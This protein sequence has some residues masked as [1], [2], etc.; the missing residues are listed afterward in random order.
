MRVLFDF[1]PNHTG[2]GFWAFQDVVE[3]GP[4]S[5][6]WDWYFI[7]EW[8]FAPGDGSA[9]EG[10]WGLGSLPKLNTENPEVKGYLFDVALHWLDFG[11]DGFRVDVPNELPNAHEFFAELRALVKAKHPEAYMVGEIWQLAPEW[12]KGD[13][14]DSLMNYALGRDVLLPYAQ[15]KTD[16][17]WAAAEL[18]RY[19][20][21]YGENVT[22]MGF[23]LVS[24]HD[25][26]RVVTELGGG[27][28]G[29]TPSPEAIE[30]L[31]LL[32]TLLYALPGAPVVFQGDERGVLGEKE[33][34]DAQRYPIQWDKADQDLFVHYRGLAELRREILALTES[35]I[36][37]YAT[38]GSILAFFRG[39]EDEVLVMAN[40]ASRL[41]A[42]D[43]PPGDWR[44][45]G[46]EV[47]FRGRVIVP[48]LQAW[49]LV[50]GG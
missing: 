37:L 2:I 44:L 33:F 5:P 27:N 8:P 19:F 31:K 40:N 48:P 17:E 30:R 46:A 32:S 41:A 35:P 23:N 36:R 14:F 18:G 11:F 43:L 39:E 9:Y 24:S 21:T 3:N 4:E 47:T 25:T 12:V 42:L 50:R 28:F 13:Q 10:W 7:W 22:A 1:V 45:L 34:Y 29:E 20:G 16:G 26:A 6:Y 49:I 15:G 38:Q